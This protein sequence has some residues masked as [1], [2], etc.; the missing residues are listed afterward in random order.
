MRRPSAIVV[1]EENMIFVKDDRCIR[2][3]DKGGEF[4]K[5]IGQGAFVKPFGKYASLPAGKRNKSV[6]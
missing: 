6:L 2:V 3:F 1:N 4:L 5:N